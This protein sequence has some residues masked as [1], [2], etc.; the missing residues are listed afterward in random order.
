[1]KKVKIIAL[2]LCF[3]LLVS[4]FAGCKK[5]QEYI[6]DPVHTESVLQDQYNNTAKE[7]EQL[8]AGIAATAPNF[9]GEFK[10]KDP[11]K[12]SELFTKAAKLYNDIVNGSIL[13]DT[14][15]GPTQIGTDRG[16]LI[17]R[18]VNDPRFYNEE[19]F[20]EYLYSC[21]T[22]EFAATFCNL[23]DFIDFDGYFY[24]RTG[25]GAPSILYAGHV[26]NMKEQ[27]D[28][29]VTFTAKVYYYK[30]LEEVPADKQ[31]LSDLPE[32]ISNL[33]VKELSYTV[34]RRNNI[35][36]F[37]DFTPMF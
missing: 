18:R 13:L 20:K 16:Y 2:I 22:E 5:K 24:C 1:M 28:D 19:S 10:M 25:V 26:F 8:E 3:L 31:L 6:S 34:V 37:S 15:V 29:S 7:S 14:T 11:P 21:F 9:E 23:G 12:I 17:F 27:T 35:W 32:D 33:E 4:V 36:A 30:S